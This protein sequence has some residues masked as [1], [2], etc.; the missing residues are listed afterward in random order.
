MLDLGT[1]AGK[2]QTAGRLPSMPGA[3]A[4]GKTPLAPGIPPIPGA[5]GQEPGIPIGTS[6]SDGPGI[7]HRK[8]QN[9]VNSKINQ[10]LCI[11]LS[12][13]NIIFIIKC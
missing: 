12:L 6:A 5:G 9:Y 4:P 3:I 2:V 11:I 8:Y 7:I 13:M 10:K 1:V